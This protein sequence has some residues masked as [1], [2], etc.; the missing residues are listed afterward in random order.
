MALGC[1]SSVY[2]TTHFWH[3]QAIRRRI[4]NWFYAIFAPE[5]AYVYST[6]NFVQ[7]RVQKS[8]ELFTYCIWKYFMYGLKCNSRLGQVTFWRTEQAA[9]YGTPSKRMLNKAHKTKDVVD[10]SARRMRNVN[11]VEHW[12]C[13]Y[14]MGGTFSSSGCAGEERVVLFLERVVL[15][16]ASAVLEVKETPITPRCLLCF[17][18][19]LPSCPE[20][21]NYSK[22]IY[23]QF[24]F[25]YVR[26]KCVLILSWQWVRRTSVSLLHVASLVCKRLRRIQWTV[27]GVAVTPGLA[28]GATGWACWVE[29]L[30]RTCMATRGCR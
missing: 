3:S 19:T 13:A 6:L 30:P 15:I 28:W 8:F 25:V 9:T 23:R 24:K 22:S 18:Q 29:T 2:I 11:Y 7:R 20:F 21:N 4:S 12:S 16:S 26:L 1:P 10:L 27:L 17:R 5:A 14:C